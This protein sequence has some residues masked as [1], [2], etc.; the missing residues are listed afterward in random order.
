M[1]NDI[2][3]DLVCPVTGEPTPGMTIQ[4]KWQDQLA[5][6][7]RTD[8]VGEELEDILSK[9]DN[10]WVR[11]FHACPACGTH[12]PPEESGLRNW[13]PFVPWPRKLNRPRNERF[14][15]SGLT[16][17]DPRTHGCGR[18]GGVVH[19]WRRCAKISGS[20][21]NPTRNCRR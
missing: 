11:A 13:T 4:V 6:Y 2:E 16:T 21:F 15:E 17:P 8:K 18:A 3:A 7:L 10:R 20:P 5:L 14:G 12:T 9:Y 19:G 1:Y